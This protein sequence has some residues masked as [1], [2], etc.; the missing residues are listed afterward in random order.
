MITIRS[1]QEADYLILR[2]VHD[3]QGKSPQN[4]GTRWFSVLFD[5]G[6]LHILKLTHYIYNSLTSS[7]LYFLFPWIWL[8]KLLY[9]RI[10]EG[11]FLLNCDL[12][13]QESIWGQEGDNDHI[14]WC[15]ISDGILIVWTPSFTP[16]FGK[17]HCPVHYRLF[18][19]IL[20]LAQVDVNE[21][22][23]LWHQKCLQ[24]LLS[25]CQLLFTCTGWGCL[26]M[27]ACVCVC[28]PSLERR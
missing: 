25:H 20:R 17:G 7:Y 27:H 4:Q 18:H 19:S 10:T 16:S 6:T 14:S 21:C 3:Y 5:R 11:P 22:S 26:C 12:H 24:I 8:H 28:T 13:S 15:F 1:H 9:N 23:Q 2:K